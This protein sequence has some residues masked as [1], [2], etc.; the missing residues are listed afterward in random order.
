MI[1]QLM[2]K[3]GLFLNRNE[4]KNEQKKSAQWYDLSPWKIWKERP[5]TKALWGYSAVFLIS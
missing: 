1:F 5:I 2:L 3:I 4:I